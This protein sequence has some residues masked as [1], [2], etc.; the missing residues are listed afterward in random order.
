MI[1]VMIV[2]RR[3]DFVIVGEILNVRLT[4]I[5]SVAAAGHGVD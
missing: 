3:R 1:V 5:L 4:L 2:F